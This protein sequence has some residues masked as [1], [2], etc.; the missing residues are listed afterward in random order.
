[1]DNFV[2]I[3]A[4]RMRLG[5]GHATGIAGERMEKDFLLLLLVLHQAN[6]QVLE[7]RVRVETSDHIGNGVPPLVDLHF[8]VSSRSRSGVH[9]K[10]VFEKL[11]G[12]DAF[13]D[14]AGVALKV[15]FSAHQKE[16]FSESFFKQPIG[17]QC[18]QINGCRRKGDEGD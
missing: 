2:G 8:N 18:Q 9:Q 3:C 5:L 12:Q 16:Y 13:V 15:L 14:V 17:A 11:E 7:H 4:D 1:M 10:K 6:A